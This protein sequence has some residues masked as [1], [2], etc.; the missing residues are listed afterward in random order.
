MKATLVIG[1]C[2]GIAITCAAEQVLSEYDWS[3]LA[4][5]GQLLGGVPTTI[6]GRAALKLVNTNDTRLQAQLVKL[7]NP[8]ITQKLYAIVGEV[9][10]EGVRGNGYLEM[11]NYFPP[12]K[13]GMMEAGYFSR[14]LGES[15]EMGKITGSS[16]WRR[17]MLPFNR[18]GTS[19]RPT[20]LELNLFLPAQGTVYLG[21]IKLVEYTGGFGFARPGS[22]SAWWPDRAGGLIG[23]IGGA[24]IGCLGSFLAWLVSKGKAQGFVVASLK[25][26]I[27]LG[28]LSAA[29]GVVA[30]G[31]RQPYGV[32]FVLLLLGVLLLG[33]LP[34]RLKQYQKRY[35]DLEM[36]KMAAMDA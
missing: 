33:I 13:P 16:N 18:T 36:R 25:L 1:L 21:P 3:N 34:A 5:A 12:A 10:Y 24:V 17:F 31:L 28:V 6:E 23:G 30:L 8:A 11:W 35:E 15:G 4:K 22:A 9:K 29:A 20:R 19:E 7:P 26:L 14:T 27:A 2:F 32:W